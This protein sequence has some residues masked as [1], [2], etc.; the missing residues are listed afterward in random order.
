MRDREV[1]GA[2]DDVGEA[3]R[4]FRRIG[5]G[6]ER[7]VVGEDMH[8]QARDP[9][10]ARRR[11]LGRHVVV[12][13][14]RGG[15][16][17]LD[18]VLDPFDRKP[19]HDRGDRGADVARIGADLV[20]EAAADVGR[21]DVDLLLGN[22]RDQRDDRAD[23]MGRLERAV[24]RQVAGDLVEAADALAGL[25]RA[26]VDALIA[27]Q[28]LGRDLGLHE[29][30]VGQL[31]VAD[32]PVEDVVGMV[33]RPVGAVFLVLDVLAQ[34]RGALIHRLER[35]DE[36]GK[37]FILDLDQVRG[38]G[39]DVAVGRDDEGDLLILEQDLAVGEHHL[40]VAR[41]RRHPGEIDAFQVL[42]G[43]NGD[44]AG[45]GLGLGGVDLDDARVGVARAM[46]VAV[47]HAREL[48]VVDVIAASLREAHVLDALALAAHA[49]QFFGALKRSGGGG[50]V[51][52]A[53]SLNSRP[54]SLAAAYW[55]ARTM[56]WYPVQ[57]QRLPEMP[58]RISLS[59]GFGF[60]CNSRWARMIMPGVQ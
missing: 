45:H 8:A 12:A 20:A 11:D 55:M 26:G 32:L 49:L 15:G 4:P 56:F 2:G 40:H 1:V 42:G 7:A 44:D 16:E 5:A 9:A 39:G 47:Q 3:C 27:Q 37:R 59:D 46:E 17:V 28:V 10:V 52:S 54:A 58:M 18:P 13:R 22:A 33:A 60:S 24:D 30:D 35:V 34:D 23:D 41:E 14:E 53:A 25:E 6:V 48:D 57:R 19:G 50:V 36:H 29:G 51:H 31:P 38:V 43:Q 21:D